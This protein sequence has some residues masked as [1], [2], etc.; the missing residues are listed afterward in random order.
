MRSQGIKVLMAKPI[1]GKTI[2]TAAVLAVAIAL[3]WFFKPDPT[4][5]PSPS[6]SV[7]PTV[8]SAPQSPIIAQNLRIPWEVIFL[9][10]G[11]MLITE[12]PGNL[13]RYS[14]T[15][16]KKTIAIPGVRHAGEGGLLG[17]ALHPKFSSN[18]YIYFYLTTNVD[19]GTTNRVER[20]EFKDDQLT[21]KKVIIEKIPG[22]SNHD[23]GRIKFGPDGMLYIA[24]GDAGVEKNAQDTQSLAG[25]ILRLRDDGTL[26]NDN[27]FKNAVYSYGHR[28][29][30]G[31][32]WDNRG[33]LWATE[34]GRSGASTGYDELNLIKKGANYGWP[35][36][37]GDA[38]RDGMVTPVRH[39]G[40]TKTWAPS[41]ITYKSGKLY[42]AGLR[43]EALY[44][45]TISGDGVSTFREHFTGVYGRLR[46]VVA[47]Q[48]GT[49]Y[50]LTNNTDGRGDPNANDDKLIRT[51]L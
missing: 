28:N 20:Y 23:G 5:A 29:V 22:A 3:I 24:T 44:E 38:T 18:R 27:P 40:P 11:G 17:M 42:F 25:K 50:I 33:R 41:G 30:Q 4:I 1:Q 16:E 36:I 21:N 8:P 45:A 19:G 10:G 47:D 39:S 26:P 34:H 46:N 14:P 12:R 6:T 37:Q 49:L 43:G 32:A 2:G 15:G 51:D 7:S 48:D 35:T 31:L 13:L 9:Q